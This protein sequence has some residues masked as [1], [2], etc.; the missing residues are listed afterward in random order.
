MACNT[1]VLIGYRWHPLARLYQA[2]VLGRLVARAGRVGFRA[3]LRIADPRLPK[4]E[5]ERWAR[6]YGWPTRHALLRFYRAASRA[7]LA[8]PATRRRS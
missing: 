3:A 6:T 1:G 7:V 2:P 4:D 5:R 8:Q